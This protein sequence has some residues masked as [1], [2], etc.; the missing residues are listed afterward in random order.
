M[1]RDAIQTEAEKDHFAKDKSPWGYSRPE[2][3]RSGNH[4]AALPDFPGLLICLKVWG[5]CDISRTWLIQITGFLPSCVQSFAGCQAQ[6]GITQ[7][8]TQGCDRQD[9]VRLLST[10][11]RSKDVH[12]FAA[13]RDFK[14]CG[15]FQKFVPM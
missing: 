4:P 15:D 5:H 3:T 1:D 9:Q 2:L 6:P 7:A 10:Q 8:W 14:F 13:T 12:F 11:A